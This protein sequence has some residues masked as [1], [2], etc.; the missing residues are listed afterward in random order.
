MTPDRQ[1]TFEPVAM[2]SVHTRAL[3]SAVI[4]SLTASDL[5][6]VAAQ[7]GVTVELLVTARDAFICAG[8]AAI[9]DL[10]RGRRW[11]QFSISLG[12]GGWRQVVASD[13][14]NRIDVWLRGR[15]GRGFF[16]LHKPPGL[17]VRFCGVD[18][19]CV[20]VLRDAL[21]GLV[22]DGAITAWTPGPYDAEVTQF[23]GDIGLALTHRWF[24]AES[25]AV[26]EHHRLRLD[27]TARIG[28]GLFSLMVIERLARR[29]YDDWER[30]D[31]WC[32]LS[33]TGRLA[34][35]AAGNVDPARA[36]SAR[37]L[38]SHQARI[39]GAASEPERTLFTRYDAALDELVPHIDAAVQASDLLWGLREILPF[40][41]VFHW[42][43]MRFDAATQQSLAA[44]MVAALSPKLDRRCNGSQ[45]DLTKPFKVGR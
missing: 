35:D 15:P 26:L 27:G 22:A 42:N 21:N 18:D 9:H 31:V 10:D 29:L 4:E 39:L 40:W 45:P 5:E 7:A 11:L 16:F 34:E 32:K 19:E 30:W 13:V 41:I 12:P 28:S 17:R 1:P 2:S 6:H 33:L 14:G 8:T 24:T 23:G 36:R 3:A 44:T 37:L 43:R 38:L 20:E 25:L